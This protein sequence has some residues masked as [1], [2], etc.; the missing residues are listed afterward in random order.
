M[1]EPLPE[2]EG[3]G[4]DLSSHQWDGR[5]THTGYRGNLTYPPNPLQASAFL[6]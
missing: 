5:A 2:G 6:R 4:V 1:T 3:W